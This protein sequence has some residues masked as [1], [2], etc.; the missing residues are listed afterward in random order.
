MIAL[1]A[2]CYNTIFRPNGVSLGD[3]FSDHHL[4]NNRYSVAIASK[5]L[6][7]STC[8]VIGVLGSADFCAAPHGVTLI[9]SNEE[10]SASVPCW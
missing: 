2:S 4:A 7:A 3:F 9:A 8:A 10:L 6:I 5:P 1:G